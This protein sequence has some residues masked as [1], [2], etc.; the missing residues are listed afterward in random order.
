[1][2]RFISALLCLFAL[3]GVMYAQSVEEIKA[4]DEYLCGEGW[5]ESLKAADNAALQDLISKISVSVESQFEN[6]EEE[7]TDQVSVDSRS[8]CRSVVNTYSQ[9]TLQNTQRIVIENEPD[10]HVFRYVKRSEVDKIF[11][12]RRLKVL[13]MVASAARAV[14]KGK[15]DDALRYYY[16]SY[17]LLQSIPSANAVTDANGHVLTH[18]IPE[19]MNEVFG[20]V[21]AYKV[22][23]QDGMAE[24]RVT[25][26]DQPVTSMDYTYF[27]GMDWSSLYGAK[28][29][30]GFVELR[31]G[32]TTENLKIKCEYEYSGEAHIDKEISTVVN[33]MKGRV[34]RNAYV[35][36][37]G[38]TPSNSPSMG[39]T[40]ASRNQLAQQT[41]PLFIEGVAQSDGGVPSEARS[42]SIT[43][44]SDSESAPY[45]KSIGKVITA[46]KSGNYASAEEC[47][48]EDGRD[49]YRR[50]ISYGNARIMGE[51][52]C[53]YYRVGETDV[54]CRSVPMSFSFQNNGRKFVED[55]T[56]TF[57]K[58]GK[59]DY[60]AFALD[61]KSTTDILQHS[62]W[63]EYARK[64]LAEFLEN[65]KTA[66][67]LKRLDYIRS[68]FDDNAVIIT[69]KVVTRQTNAM[70]EM[71]G[72]YLNNKYVQYTRQGKE[73]Y[74]RNLERCFESNEY[75]NIRFANNDIVKAGVGGE[76]YGIQIKQDYYSTNYGDTGYLFL[77]VDLN[78]PKQPVI[79]VRSWQPERDPNFG[80]IDLSH[81]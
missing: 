31:P 1:M 67:A 40:Q 71:G 56:F 22:S 48:T 7:I 24:I 76:V 14:E 11:E 59:I 72:E 61:E 42:Q 54:T 58:E 35:M 43:M 80:L 74:L 32:M 46:I 33:V 18:W 52:A 28:D 62:M 8:A 44:L 30:R 49:M 36:V 65:Y 37:T 25:F 10:A 21:K 12:S 57:D 5:G 16:W 53:A 15:V 29:G 77:M 3:S 17:C 4:S 69:G 34:F 19:Q 64:V 50:L 2:K 39:R 55:V 60:L 9:A 79:K 73:Q 66:Y 26:K 6:I 41:P 27:D 20:G 47:F 51:T 13:D 75:I 38:E 78:D 81:F 45:A 70:G 63:S 68:I 23:E